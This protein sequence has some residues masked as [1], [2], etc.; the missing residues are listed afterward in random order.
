MLLF[1]SF[2]QGANVYIHLL[3]F[4]IRARR[5]EDYENESDYE[6]DGEK[7]PWLIVRKEL[8]YMSMVRLLD[9]REEEGEEK[10]VLAE[11]MDGKRKK[12]DYFFEENYALLELPDRRSIK[13][14]KL[15]KNDREGEEDWRENNIIT[16]NGEAMSKSKLCVFECVTNGKS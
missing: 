4:W 15:I 1:F 11:R 13:K 8:S 14:S 10:D 9:S 6:E 7:D 2:F 3:N 5:K 16:V 12:I